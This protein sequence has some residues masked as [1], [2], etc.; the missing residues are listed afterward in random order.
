MKTTMLAIVSHDAM[1]HGQL[2][3]EHAPLVTSAAENLANG[4][5]EGLN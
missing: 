4:T 1:S 5:E 3:A 2:R